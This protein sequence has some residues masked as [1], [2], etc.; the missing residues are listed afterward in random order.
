MGME[1]I[2][3]GVDD[4]LTHP[5]ELAESMYAIHTAA[6]DH[7]GEL[8][9]KHAINPSDHPPPPDYGPIDNTLK[10][11][12]RSAI[13]TIPN[14]VDAALFLTHEAYR[15]MHQYAIDTTDLAML[16][17]SE[18]LLEEAAQLISKCEPPEE[19]T[20]TIDK[21][22]QWFE[23]PS[24]DC[25]EACMHVRQACSTWPSCPYDLCNHIE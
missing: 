20:N 17:V 23:T 14:H 4:A 24:Q 15:A 1:C 11:M 8:R 22:R 5:H 13:S 21:T 18:I 7:V 6:S 3:C 9:A 2:D 12:A 16:D 19:Y 10:Q 25:S